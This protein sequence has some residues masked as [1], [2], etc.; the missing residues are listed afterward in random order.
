[1]EF[2]TKVGSSLD[3]KDKKKIPFYLLTKW[4]LLSGKQ[5]SISNMEVCTFPSRLSPWPRQVFPEFF[6]K[7]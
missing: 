2:Q 5:Q 3:K 7:A 6:K 1:M 4:Q